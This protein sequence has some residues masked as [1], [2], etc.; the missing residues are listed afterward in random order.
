MEWL[1][2]EKLVIVLKDF[3]TGRQHCFTLYGAF[4]QVQST[5]NWFKSSNLITYLQNISWQQLVK[6]LTLT[7]FY[8]S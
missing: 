3:Y 4:L 6:V 8:F 2:L 7:V 5:N 1:N